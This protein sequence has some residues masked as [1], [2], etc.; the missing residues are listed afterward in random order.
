MRIHHILKNFA[1]KWM[2]WTGGVV[3]MNLLDN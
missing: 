3:V 2:F 1:V